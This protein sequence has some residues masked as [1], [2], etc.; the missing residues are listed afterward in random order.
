MEAAV[1]EVVLDPGAADVRGLAI[2]EDELAMLD[3][4]ELVRGERP[5]PLADRA[6]AVRRDA[7]S[8]SM[9]S[10]PAAARLLSIVF[11]PNHAWLPSASR[12]IRTFTPSR[13]FCSSTGVNWS[14]MTPGLKPYCMMW[15]DDV[16]PLMSAS[17]RG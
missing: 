10:T 6:A 16:A 14:P 5:S 8:W 9:T 11:V 3:S 2:D 4:A 7:A 13:A 12:M 15:I 1:G 17:I